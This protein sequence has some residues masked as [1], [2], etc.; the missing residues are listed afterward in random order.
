MSTTNRIFID[1]S[2]LIEAI[3]GKKIDFYTSLVSDRSNHF[4]VNDIV[5]SEYVYFILGLNSGISPRTIKEKKL[6]GNI[7]NNSVKEIN[8]L[9]DFTFISSD[10]RL[11]DY[12][13]E[14]MSKY[15]LLPNDA[16][17]LATCKIH[18]INMLASHD[19]DFI[20]PC[21]EEGIHLLS[22]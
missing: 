10:E 12:V 9:K 1:S 15:N 11:L 6:I 18:S 8:I 13:P 19:T 3:K 17:I 16:I 14:L 4:F 2:I 7:L 5:V 22:S 21:N 20:E